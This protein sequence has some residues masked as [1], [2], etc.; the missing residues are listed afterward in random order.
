MKYQLESSPAT[1]LCY[2][3]LVATTEEE[4]LVAAGV[5]QMKHEWQSGSN[6]QIVEEARTHCTTT[7][8]GANEDKEEEGEPADEEGW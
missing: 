4:G 5:E 7:G 3:C 6:P 1:S 2:G 8:S